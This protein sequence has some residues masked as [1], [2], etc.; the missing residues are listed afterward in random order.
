MIFNDKRKHFLVDRSFQLHYAVY[1]VLTLLIISAVGMAGNYYGIWASVMKAFS[2]ESLQQSLITSAQMNEYELSRH[3]ASGAGMNQMPSL[4][5]YRETVLL[6]QHQKEM[7]REIMDDAHRKTIA[8]GILLLFFIG[9]G[10]IFLTHK[11]AGPLFKLTQYFQELKNGNLTVRIKFRKFDEVNYLAAHFNEVA[12]TLD[13]SI[14]R[15]KRI[16]KEPATD[17]TIAEVEKE[18]SKFKTT[19]E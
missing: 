18:I 8:L 5:M 11:V 2:E 15:I 12:A 9:W 17:A 7:I 1:I 3:P 13:A 6:S 14:S 19:S 16:L 4:R 10:S